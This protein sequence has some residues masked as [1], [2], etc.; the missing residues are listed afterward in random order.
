[1]PKK[2]FIGKT[3]FEIN[4]NCDINACRVHFENNKLIATILIES[5]DGFSVMRLELTNEDM[6]EMTGENINWDNC[7][8]YD[9][10][11]DDIINRTLNN[12]AKSARF[13]K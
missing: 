9:I 11:P 12:S 10:S 1:M 2:Y 6:Y 7:E 4:D 5:E 3:Q 8:Y 13:K